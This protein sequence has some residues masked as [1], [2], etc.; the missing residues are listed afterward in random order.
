MYIDSM[1][2]FSFPLSFP[3]ESLSISLDSKFEDHALFLYCVFHSPQFVR[4]KEKN[5]DFFIY[6]STTVY[7]DCFHKLDWYIT[8]L[9]PVQ[10]KI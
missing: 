5:E 4:K 7:D 8:K 1:V 2:L 10:M 6:I 9:I 3:I